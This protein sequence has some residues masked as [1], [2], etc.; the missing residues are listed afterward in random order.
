MH[1]GG[2]HFA[3][4]VMAE[5]GHCRRAKGLR[6]CRDARASSPAPVYTGHPVRQ[7]QRAAAR[8]REP[9][10]APCSPGACAAAL[11]TRRVPAAA[12]DAMRCGRL[13][14]GTSPMDYA[15][16]VLDALVGQMCRVHGGDRVGCAPK[17]SDSLAVRPATTGPCPAKSRLPLSWPRSR[18]LKIPGRSRI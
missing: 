11:R 1:E 9:E 4:R 7:R 2:H 18:A 3:P 8:R 14:T 17:S 6:N 15:S 10:A 5:Q 12:C 13:A 16:A